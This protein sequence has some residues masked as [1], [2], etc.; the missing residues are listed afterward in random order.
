MSEKTSRGVGGPDLTTVGAWAG[1]GSAGWV[2]TRKVRSRDCATSLRRIWLAWRCAVLNG[3][4][5]VTVQWL[6]MKSLR[7]RCGGVSDSVTG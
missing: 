4:A 3:S 5:C 6:A 2:G 7:R 1:G